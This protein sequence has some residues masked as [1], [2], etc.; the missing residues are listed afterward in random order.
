MQ[1]ERDPKSVG[2]S[3]IAA[4][5]AK[6]RERIRLLPRAEAAINDY[7]TPAYSRT[8]IANVLRLVDF[9]ALSLIGGILYFSHVLATDPFNPAFPIAI[10]AFSALTVSIASSF[11]GYS[12]GALRRYYRQLAR[13]MTIWAAV[14]GLFM[15]FAFFARVSDD[16]SRLWLGLWFVTGLAYFALGRTI[17][18]SFIMR[19]TTDGRLHRRAVI[20]GGGEAAEQLITA[21]NAQAESDIRICGIFDDRTDGRS[22]EMVAGY[23]RLGTISQLVE[24]GRRAHIDLLILSLPMSAETRILQMLKKLWVLPIDIRISAQSSRLRFRPRSYS[25]VGSVPFLDLFDRPIDE[26]NSV[27]KRVF[28]VSFSIFGLVLFSPIMLATAIAVKATSKGPVLFRQKRYGFNNEIIEILKF[29]SMYQ[30]QSDPEAKK[31]VTRDDPRVTTVG[32]FI[33]RTSI[34]ELPQLISVI[35]GDLSLVGPRP[36]AINAHTHDELWDD[37]VDGYFARHRV[38]PGVTGWAQING[39]RGEVDNREKIERRIE[40]DL[41]Y[42]ENWSVLFDLYICM[43]TP[44]ALLKQENAY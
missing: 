9:L 34:D 1:I 6:S 13:V 37:V 39:W 27:I 11:Q 41:F 16:I 23:Q 26:W 17:V 5:Q 4:R 40:H 18:R 30:E 42:I 44:F 29:R 21:L 12:V 24:F 28:D 15:V 43:A 35:K 8:V 20:V 22:P 7:G 36:H 33:R 38:K 14:L 10:L 32:R 31:A 25:H 2:H 3:Q 19:W